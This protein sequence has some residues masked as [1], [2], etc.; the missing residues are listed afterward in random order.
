[1]S[2]DISF[3]E[4]FGIR[5]KI[6]TGVTDAVGLAERQIASVLAELVAH[7]RKFFLLD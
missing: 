1:M 3:V 6:W 7:P 4:I 5:S 2:P